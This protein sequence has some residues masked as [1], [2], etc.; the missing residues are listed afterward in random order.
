MTLRLLVLAEQLD[1]SVLQQVFTHS[2]WAT[3]RVDSYERL[4]FLGDS[5]LSLCVTTELY[6]RFPDVAEGHLARLRAY[7]VSRA[8]CA[9]VAG[10]LGLAKRL[11]HHAGPASE[12]SEF[13]QLET[14]QNILADLT[15]A[16]I[17]AL[18]LAFGFETVRPAVVEAFNEHIKYAVSSYIDYKTELQEVLARD[19]LTVRY[20][21]LASTG[22]AHER[23]FEVEARV[24][25]EALGH[26]AGTSKKRAEQQA[27]QAALKELRERQCRNT[28][29]GRGRRRQRVTKTD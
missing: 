15:E 2:S 8:T 26:G 3:A 25:D 6:R 10:R 1:Q 20:E 13:S 18:Y 17:G 11:R 5:V 21:L 14:N 23:H 29:R 9:R 12:S 7:V 28:S 16:L 4:E 27:A 22:P 19:G 24:A